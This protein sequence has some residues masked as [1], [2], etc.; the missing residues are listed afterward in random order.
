MVYQVG[1]QGDVVK[2]IQEVIG[3]TPDGDFGPKTEAAVKNWQSKKG[4]LADGIVGAVTLSKMGINISDNIYTLAQIHRTVVSKGYRWFDDKDLHLNIVGVRNSNFG[5]AVTN[6][7]D[8]RLTLSYKQNGGWIYKAV[9]Y[10]HLR[11]PRD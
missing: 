10:T 7:F 11:A 3:V 8:D 6:L 4:L 1:S 5:D 9:S 2:Q